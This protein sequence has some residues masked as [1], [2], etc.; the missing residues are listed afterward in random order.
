MTTATRG[1]KGQAIGYAARVLGMQ[2]VIVVPHGNSV[3]KNAAMR[4]Q[5]VELIE[6]GPDNQAAREY[7]ETLAAQR[8]LHFIPPFHPQ[9]VRGISTYPLEFM[10]SVPD[11]DTVYVPIGMGS[12]IAA[13]IAIRDALGLKTRIVGVVSENAPAYALSFEAGRVVT[14]DRSDT[15]ADGVACRVP[16]AEALAIIQKG[17]ERVVTVSE[18]EIQNAIRAYFTDTHNLAEGAGALPLAALLKERSSMAGK[19][20]GLVL[21]GGNIDQ[22]VFQHVLKS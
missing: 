19:K 14:T 20:V 9:L 10:C 6:H 1:N 11:L 12:G 21:T 17:A 7:S 5:G 22:E 16:D 3:E 4:A 13:N 18:A 2:A 15:L 8:G